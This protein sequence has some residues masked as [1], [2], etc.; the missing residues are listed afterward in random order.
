M[1]LS[2]HLPPQHLVVPVVSPDVEEPTL[3]RLW[4]ASGSSVGNAFLSLFLSCSSGLALATLGRLALEQRP[5][6]PLE[7]RDLLEVLVDAREA[8]VRDLVQLAEL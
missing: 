1:G 3:G 2:S 5:E 6:L 4:N 8:D 7:V